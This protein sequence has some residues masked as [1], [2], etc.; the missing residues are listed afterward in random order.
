MRRNA[1]RDN[2]TQYKWGGSETAVRLEPITG[3]LVSMSSRILRGSW[4]TCWGGLLVLG[5][6]LGCQ[7]R[8]QAPRNDVQA[9]ATVTATDVQST[10]APSITAGRASGGD[11]SEPLAKLRTEA[12]RRRDCL[13]SPLS[14]SDE[15]LPRLLSF[16]HE[17]S[18][19]RNERHLFVPRDTPHWAV[20]QSDAVVER[21]RTE[22]PDVGPISVRHC[23]STTPRRI[24][25]LCAHIE[26]RICEPWMPN[27]E[28]LLAALPQ[29]L[30][31]LVEI[32]GR[33][34]ARCDGETCLPVPYHRATGPRPDQ[35]WSGLFTLPYRASDPR[36]PVMSEFGKGVCGGD[37]DCEVTGCGNHC[38]AWT[39]IP[40]GAHCP[41]YG[42]LADAH[43]GCVERSCV[44]FV[45][46][47]RITVQATV[48][49]EGWPAAREDSGERA[50][51]TGDAVI[52]DVLHGPWFRRQ[53]ERLQH[54]QNMTLPEA[55]VLEASL[56]RRFRV[57]HPKVTIAGEPGPRWLE[58]VV[59]HLPIPMPEASSKHGVG[60]RVRLEADVRLSAG[61]G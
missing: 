50:E 58:E 48:L 38:E 16:R 31:L 45:Q 1:A 53:L 47:T 56:D 7:T 49:V 59:S 25:S 10:R 5:L 26:A 55:F 18:G 4:R 17:V 41:G 11:D 52:R 37:G 3:K 27:A 43:C 61:P 42:A 40:H 2:G 46:P 29:G 21:L 13:Q 33:V 57:V 30:G 23:E 60:K 54:E 36:S 22:F 35:I 19:E 15:E 34:G 14:P 6:L 8:N 24:E 51:P 28:R 39:E 20:G 44:W 12:I 32:V 9:A